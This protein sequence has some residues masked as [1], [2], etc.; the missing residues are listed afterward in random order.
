MEEG[1]DTANFHSSPPSSV[2][3]RWRTTRTSHRLIII[4]LWGT[5]YA[6]LDIVLRTPDRMCGR[7]D[8]FSCG[9]RRRYLHENMRRLL[10]SIRRGGVRT[11]KQQKF[12]FYPPSAFRSDCLVGLI[13]R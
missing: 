7:Q 11:T 4:A 6:E 2:R 8:H 12:N 5:I 3:R 10:S 9:A 1:R 13:V